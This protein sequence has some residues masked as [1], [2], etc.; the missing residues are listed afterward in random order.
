MDKNLRKIIIAGVAVVS[1]CL[2]YY[3]VIKP[4]IDKQT[5]KD[6]V[7]H[8]GGRNVVVAPAYRALIESCVRSGG[9][10]RVYLDDLPKD[11]QK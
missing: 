1:F 8:F 2:I 5:Y 9:I 7:A 10:K 4:E 11:L 6:C 3:F